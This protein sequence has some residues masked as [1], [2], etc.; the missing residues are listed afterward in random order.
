[1]ADPT[2]ILRADAGVLTV[3]I[4]LTPLLVAKLE[5]LRHAD[6]PQGATPPSPERMAE[7]ALSAG[8]NLLV[9]EHCHGCEGG[10]SRL[11]LGDA[12]FGPI[13]FPHSTLGA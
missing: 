4:E 12:R 9:H 1:M 6:L 13:P 10:A 11:P 5:V 7:R 8:L 3:T 2:T